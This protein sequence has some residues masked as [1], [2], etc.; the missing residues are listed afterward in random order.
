MIL[1]EKATD[2]H[3]K[4]LQVNLDRQ[5][6]GTFAEIGAGQEVA[7]WFFRVGGAA[8]TIAKTISAYDMLVSDAIYGECER[9]VSRE[10]LDAMLDREQALVVER[11]KDSRGPQSAFFTFANTVVAQ[12]YRGTNRCHGWLGIRFQSRPGDEDNQIIIHLLMKDG[13]APLQQEALGIVGV[14]LVYGASF[15]YHEPELLLESLLD[16]LTTDRIEIDMIEFSGIEFRHVDHR[17]MSLRLVQLG[18]S[19]AAMFGPDGKVMQPSASLRK[20][21]ILVERGSFKPVSN[22]NLDMIRAARHDF[23]ASDDVDEGSVVE[24]MEITMNNLRAE[25]D[26]DISDFLARV[27]LLSAVGKI[28]LV[29]DYFQ[30]WRLGSYLRR[31]TDKPIGVTM[32]AASVRE[33]FNEA[34]YDE[35][36]GGILESFGRLFQNQLRLY[37]YPFLD[38]DSGEMLKV[39]NLR[40]PD[41]LRNLYA[42]LVER[43]MVRQLESYNEEC[44]HIFSRELLKQISS[45]PGEWEE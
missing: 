5:R 10:R 3:Q 19:K 21:P 44:L 12:N 29:S 30:Y 33:L 16:N 6:Y 23:S 31:Y 24:L 40:V 27:D 13:E 45:G 7:R 8:G 42:H 2:T 32:G 36:D 4:A 43:G 1:R 15:L 18:L 37:V 28:V 20:K 38:P 26:I 22:V 41:H 9:Y 14:N 11:L 34:H 25:G 39:D 35:L 17:A